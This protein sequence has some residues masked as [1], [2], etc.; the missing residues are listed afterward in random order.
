MYRELNE[1]IINLRNAKTVS[2]EQALIKKIETL[3]DGYCSTCAEL[4]RIQSLVSTYNLGHARKEE[5][6]ENA[7]LPLL[8]NLKNNGT[9]TFSE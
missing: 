1:I 9:A 2:E 3:L 8:A 6:I 4:L 7:L 5:L